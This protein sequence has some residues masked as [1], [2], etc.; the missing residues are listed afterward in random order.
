MIDISTFKQ[1]HP[2]KDSKQD[3]RFASELEL[4]PEEM[5]QERLPRDDSFVLC[6]PK[7]IPGFDMNKK[8]W[9]L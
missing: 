5:S 1:M 6:L 7:T 3:S 2:S 4:T 8:E 9:S